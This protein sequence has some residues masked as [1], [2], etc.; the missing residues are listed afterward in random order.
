VPFVVFTEDAVDAEQ[1]KVL[2]TESFKFFAMLQA[3]FK[4]NGFS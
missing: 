3:F 1:F 4:Y 2:F